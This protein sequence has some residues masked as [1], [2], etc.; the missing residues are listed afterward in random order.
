MTTAVATRKQRLRTLE[1]EIR[2]G[3]EEFYYVGQKL[4]EIRDDEL[5]KEDGFKTWEAYCR[6]RW[7][8]SR[9]YA[10]KLITASDYR[11][12]L[13]DVDKLYTHAE[14]GWSEASVR[15]LTRIPDKRQ[16]GILFK[17]GERRL[18]IL[19]GDQV[20]LLD[21]EPQARRVPSQLWRKR[22]NWS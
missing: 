4:K 20:R 19:E 1:K 12:K 8:W 6:D 3:M 16:A 10:Y 21:I 17:T 22:L 2:T 5:Y 9:D 14:K 13:P 15:E 7:D 18:L 11:A